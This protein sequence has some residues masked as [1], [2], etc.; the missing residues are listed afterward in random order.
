MSRGPHASAHASTIAHAHASAI[1]SSTA[2][3]HS[4]SG[5]NISTPMTSRSF[6]VASDMSKWS[7]ADATAEASRLSAKDARETR[8]SVA[9]ESSHRPKLYVA[10]ISSSAVLNSSATA[11]L[12]AASVHPSD[13]QA[14][15]AAAMFASSNMASLSAAPAI[16]L[17]E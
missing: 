9:S 10:H 6:F 12:R 17:L 14:D 13:A 15:I 4:I 7:T 5:V 1:R 3:A 8:A 2:S 16:R 11:S